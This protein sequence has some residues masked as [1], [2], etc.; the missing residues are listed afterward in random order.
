MNNNSKDTPVKKRLVQFQW[1]GENEM[2]LHTTLTDEYL[3]SKVEEYWN[4]C[5]ES[6]EFNNGFTEWFCEQHDDRVYIDSYINI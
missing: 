3:N 1:D 5:Q 4:L 6:D 2:L